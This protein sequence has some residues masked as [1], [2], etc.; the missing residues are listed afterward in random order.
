MEWKAEAASQGRP[1]DL[2]MMPFLLR[3]IW[4]GALV[5]FSVLMFSTFFVTT[6]YQAIIMISLVGICWAIACWVPFA[7]IMEVRTLRI[8]SLLSIVDMVASL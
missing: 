7:I 2:P 5:L 3:N 6:V 1:L 4:M 8:K